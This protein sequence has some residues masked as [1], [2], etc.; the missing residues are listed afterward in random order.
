MADL[1]SIAARIVGVTVR[2]LHAARI[3]G[4]DLQ[5][6]KDALDTVEQLQVD[7]RAVNTAIT[8]LTSIDNQ[9]WDAL[10]IRE[11]GQGYEAQDA[12]LTI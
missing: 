6:L 11:A 12:Y 4:E 7:L 10:D 8:S 3:P 2:A 1:F 9:E 5:Q